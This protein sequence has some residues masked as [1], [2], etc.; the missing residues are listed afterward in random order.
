MD[1]HRSPI[2]DMP[3]PPPPPASSILDQDDRLSRVLSLQRELDRELS[4]LVKDEPE[5]R[6]RSNPE[7]ATDS[8]WHLDNYS[9]GGGSPGR[10][11]FSRGRDDYY[12]RRDY[13]SRQFSRQSSGGGGSSR[14]YHHDRGGR[15]RGF[16]S[17]RYSS[18]GY[19]SSQNYGGGDQGWSAPD[20]GYAGNSWH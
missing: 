4:Y 16:E 6:G 2:R 7:N 20:R 12:D 18:G 15:E 3:P 1:E 9:R 11:N 13:Q 17:S 8:N 5:P 19:S 10:G 14:G